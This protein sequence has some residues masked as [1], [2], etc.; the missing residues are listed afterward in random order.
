MRLIVSAL[1]VLFSLNAVG[2]IETAKDYYNNFQFLKVTKLLSEKQNKTALEELYLG[3]SYAKLGQ[4]DE[5]YVAFKSAVKKDSSNLIFLNQLAEFQYQK[6]DF[7]DAY[8]TYQSLIDREPANPFYYKK[9]GQVLSHLPYHEL[10]N[11]LLK[12]YNS[13]ELPGNSERRQEILVEIREKGYFFRPENAYKQVI[14][15][16]PKDIESRLALNE[17]LLKSNNAAGADE[18]IQEC[19]KEFPQNKKFLM[20]AIKLSYSFRDFKDLSTKSEHYYSLFDSNLVVQ[21][22][23]GIAQYRLT[24]YEKAIRLLENVDDVDQESEL[25]PYYL[26]LCHRELE[27]NEKA[28]IYLEKAIN[29]GISENIEHYYLNLA[30]VYERR[31]LFNQSIKYYKAAYAKS[32]EKILL[33]HLARNYDEFYKDKTPAL[34][35]YQLYLAENDTANKEFF[36]Y[37]KTRLQEIAAEQHFIENN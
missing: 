33:Y 30:N 29:L 10:F 31:K 36:E 5:A 21:K 3:K 26:G 24:N 2:Q 13:G 16:N 1:L 9:L 19:L 34:K 23:H 28:T 20:Q 4:S 12:V 27:E 22:L 7:L 6:Q 18:A 37:T 14:Y 8:L 25:V 35:Y 17:L 32:K 15:L 11:G